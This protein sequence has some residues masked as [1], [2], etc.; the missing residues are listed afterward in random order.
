MTFGVFKSIQTID[1]RF[2][3]TSIQLP[4]TVISADVIIRNR[5]KIDNK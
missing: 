4:I 1:D 3:K 2:S 5:I